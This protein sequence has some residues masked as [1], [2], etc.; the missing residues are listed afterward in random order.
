MSTQSIEYCA[1]SR[2][3]LIFQQ[4]L[5]KESHFKEFDRRFYDSIIEDIKKSGNGT[6]ISEIPDEK[7]LKEANH[8]YDQVTER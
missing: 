3:A 2:Q 8:I 4:I 1:H 7:L 6:M 5:L